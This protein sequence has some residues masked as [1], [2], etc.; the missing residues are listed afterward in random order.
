MIEREG[1]WEADVSEQRGKQEE[2]QTPPHQR[3]R[4]MHK[5]LPPISP[6]NT[7]EEEEEEF[8]G[9]LLHNSKIGLL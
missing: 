4:E 9:S 3:P 7:S 1:L 8:N 2:K 6:P 5:R